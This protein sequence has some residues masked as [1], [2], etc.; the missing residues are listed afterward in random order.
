MTLFS[1]L[2]VL[3]FCHGLAVRPLVFPL[4]PRFPPTTCFKL[5]KPSS[6]IIE[7]LYPMSVMYQST[8]ILITPCCQRRIHR[9]CYQSHVHTSDTCGLCREPFTVHEAQ[10]AIA[11]PEPEHPIRQT[12]MELREQQRQQAI[13]DLEA[14]L[15]P[16]ALEAR[17]E[18][19]CLKVLILSEAVF[20]NREVKRTT[21]SILVVKILF[22]CR[23]LDAIHSHFLSVAIFSF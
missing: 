21:F 5:L 11:N 6:R 19:V 8:A 23:F 14:L 1:F 22:T 3:I 4:L 20:W 16:G 2:F 7:R 17:I 13:R 18:Q 10:A 12:A 9:W 15:Q